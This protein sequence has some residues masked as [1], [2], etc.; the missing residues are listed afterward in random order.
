MALSTVVRNHIRN[1][2][3]PKESRQ[4]YFLLVPPNCSRNNNSESLAGAIDVSMRH[5]GLTDYLGPVYCKTWVLGKENLQEALQTIDRHVTPASRRT[6]EIVVAV[7]A[8]ANVG[9]KKY[10]WGNDEVSIEAVLHWAI[11]C[12]SV[13]VVLLLGCSTALPTR[14]VPHSMDIAVIA[15]THPIS[16]DHLWRFLLSYLQDFRFYTRQE[17]QW[18][19]KLRSLHAMNAACNS[20]ITRNKVCQYP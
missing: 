2:Q 8:H 4:A 6:T 16:Y 14:L 13:K 1:H 5:D 12:S 19:V 9:R 18:G 7:L 20:E 10:A 3:V 15:V 11:S 17:C